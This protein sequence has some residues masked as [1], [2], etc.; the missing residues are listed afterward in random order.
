MG[1]ETLSST[2]YILSDEPSIPFYSTSNRYKNCS[3]TVGTCNNLVNVYSNF[4][5]PT[6]ITGDFNSWHTIWGSPRNNEI[7]NTLAHFIHQSPLTL[8]NDG[9]PTH[10]SIHNTFTHDDLTLSSATLSLESVWF[11]KSSAFGSDHFPIITALF[12]TTS[13]PT[14]P[15][16][17]N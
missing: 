17:S 4:F 3:C 14:F 7:G 5:T 8:L 10:F 15:P 6:L 13:T 1:S 11:I 9:S 12:D 16:N 2:C